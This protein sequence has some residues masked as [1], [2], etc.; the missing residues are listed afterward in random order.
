MP[1]TIRNQR[2]LACCLARNN[3]VRHTDLPPRGCKLNFRK[4]S[5][6]LLLHAPPVFGFLADKFEPL[7]ES[8]MR[9][10]DEA[11]LE[12]SWRRAKEP[13]SFPDGSG[14]GLQR[15]R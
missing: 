6:R 3:L 1:R 14:G 8:L 15:V 9:V 5:T 11:D 12:D 2:N 10:E 13:D 4:A 7:A